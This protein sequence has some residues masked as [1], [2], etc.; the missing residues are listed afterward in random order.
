[1][2]KAKR[3]VFKIDTLSLVECTDGYYLYDTVVGMNITMR[4]KTEQDAYV[5]ALLW[6]Q[7]SLASAKLNYKILN[8]KVESFLSQFDRDD[9]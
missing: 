3:N 1:M 4:A 5:E 6:Y 9:D 7:K 2:G 8:D